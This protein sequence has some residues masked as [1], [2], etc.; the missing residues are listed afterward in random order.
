MSVSGS[1][2]ED[3]LVYFTMWVAAHYHIRNFPIRNENVSSYD[4]VLFVM[5]M[6]FS[7]LFKT[8]HYSTTQ[9]SNRAHSFLKALKSKLGVS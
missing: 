2:I 6:C 7:I 4:L 8:Q 5:Q 3:R 1:Y 9:T